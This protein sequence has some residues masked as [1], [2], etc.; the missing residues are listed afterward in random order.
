MRYF[1]RFFD[2]KVTTVYLSVHSAEFYIIPG[3][4]PCLTGGIASYPGQLNF[5]PVS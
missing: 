2:T 5:T 3:G 1:E 4:F